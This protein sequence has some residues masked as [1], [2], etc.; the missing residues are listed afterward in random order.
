MTAP[1]AGDLIFLPS[2]THGTPGML[3]SSVL[4]Q[5]GLPRSLLPGR[6]AL[7]E[8]YAIVPTTE[9]TLC[10]VVTVGMGETARLLRRNLEAALTDPRLDEARSLWIPLMGTGAGQ[11]TLV[12]SEKHI[13]DVLDLTGWSR[14]PGVRI[15]VSRPP[16]DPRERMAS[17][18]D[19]KSAP[20]P[21]PTAT[22]AGLPP[23]ISPPLKALLEFAAAL[24]ANKE[25]DRGSL[26]TRLLTIALALANAPIIPQLV[27]RDR[28]AR[29]FAMALDLVRARAAEALWQTYFQKV[30]NGAPELGAAEPLVL[31]RNAADVL[32]H[33]LERAQADAREVVEIDDLIEAMLVQTQ[34]RFIAL[35]QACEI[36]TAALSDAYR[37]TAK[38][39]VV[40]ALVSDVASIEDRLGYDVY[41]TALK[42]FLL[43][44]STPPPLSVSIQA[45]WGAGKSTLMHL[46]RNA[47][48]PTAAHPDEKITRDKVLSIGRVMEFLGKTAEPLPV[49]SGE[50]ARQRWTV[51]FN[52]WKYENATQVWAGLVDAIIDQISQKLP[53]AE[54]ELFLLRLNLSRVDDGKVRQRVYDRVANVVW[55]KGYKVFAG[56][57]T[58]I[59]ASLGLSAA[60]DKVAQI[61]NVEGLTLLARTGGIAGA[62]VAAVLLWQ[63]FQ[64]KQKEA[65]KEPADFSLAD[66][67]RVP[68]YN[69]SVGAV[70]H[71][72]ADLKKVLSVTPKINGEHSPIVIFIDDLDRCSP[73]NVAAVVEGISS[74]LASDLRCLFVIGMDPQMVAAALETAHQ[75]VRSRLP[76]WERS[77][78]LGWRFMD[79]FVQLPFTIPPSSQLDL[80]RYLGFVVGATPLTAEEAASSPK[81]AGTLAPSSA[82][83]AT[84]NAD[85]PDEASSAPAPKPQPPPEADQAPPR[86]NPSVGIIVRR[87]AGLM[88]GNPRELKRLANV[89]RLYLRLRDSRH[90]IDGDWRAPNLD[91]YA[92]WIA[93]TLRW[94]DMMRWLQWGADEAAWTPLESTKALGVRRLRVLEDQAA[95]NVEADAWQKAVATRLKLPDEIDWLRDPKLFEFFDREADT[96]AEARLSAAAE[97]E[98]W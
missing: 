30:Y 29:N 72:Y 6:E 93:L 54:R 63:A 65:K 12:A 55:R 90:D 17:R 57:T 76:K 66:L 20:R 82:P 24:R 85:M 49:G 80:D 75:Q 78:P 2:D 47:L 23:K 56:W 42:E 86:E 51:W 19:R 31:S 28:A 96:P 50:P 35:L 81:A 48:D 15:L 34:G 87:A 21:P 61:T 79:K 8:G 33:A 73:N 11:L 64:G 10:F 7:A 3:N 91:Q 1:P 16:G 88:S 46:V 38:A 89:A 27:A 83:R 95:L 4:D 77:V 9:A 84:A 25:R 68:D 92:R 69:A 71:A 36:T 97:L 13:L 18:P 44:V 53:P 74:I 45:P 60:A 94:P 67:I 70:H 41:A 59:A 98:F 22:E 32:R 52:A 26:S 43:D 62:V 5:L 58:A 40:M 14:R 39:R 37:E